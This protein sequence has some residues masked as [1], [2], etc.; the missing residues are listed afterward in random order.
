MK[1]RVAGL[2]A[3]HYQV[4]RNAHRDSDGKIVLRILP[5][6]LDLGS[7]GA[8]GYWEAPAAVPMF[9]CP[10]PIGVRITD[11]VIRYQIDILRD[12]GSTAATGTVRMVPRCPDLPQDKH[13][14]CERICTG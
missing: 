14:F 13:D 6:T 5:E 1:Y 8:D 7:G 10:S 4:T 2:P 11:Q 9:M 3:G 12:N